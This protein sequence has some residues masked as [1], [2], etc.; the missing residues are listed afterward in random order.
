[1]KLSIVV[2][3]LCC[4]SLLAALAP[5]AGC[6]VS[7][8]RRCPNSRFTAR[9]CRTGNRPQAPSWRCTRRTRLPRCLI[10]RG[11]VDKDGQFVIGL[12][13]HKDDAPPAGDYAVTIIWPEDQD[14]NKQFDSTPPDRLKNRYNNVKRAKWNVHVAETRNALETFNVE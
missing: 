7:R 11:I 9:S 3:R 1:M 12:A 4:L 10:R 8:P 14:P 5:L 6:G 2:S 13:H